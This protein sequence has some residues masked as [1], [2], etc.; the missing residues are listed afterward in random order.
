MIRVSPLVSSLWNENSNK[1]LLISDEAFP[2]TCK[3]LL[4]CKL[5]FEAIKQIRVSELVQHNRSERVLETWTVQLSCL[6]E[7]RSK[8]LYPIGESWGLTNEK[9]LFNGLSRD[10]LLFEDDQ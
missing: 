9:L 1:D 10:G 5:N 8:L 4:G 2:F 3:A 6:E 7:R